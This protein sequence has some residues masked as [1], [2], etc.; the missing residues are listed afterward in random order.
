M[1]IDIVVDV[2]RCRTVNRRHLPFPDAHDPLWWWSILTTRVIVDMVH[3]AGPLLQLAWLGMTTTTTT[4]ELHGIVRDAT[5]VRRTLGFP[6]Y[7]RRTP[8]IVSA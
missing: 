2:N 4:D 7:S 6:H 3:S 8:R 5:V 1:V